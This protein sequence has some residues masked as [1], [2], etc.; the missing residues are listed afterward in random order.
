M[1]PFMNC[2]GGAASSYLPEGQSG[3]AKELHLRVTEERKEGKAS[4]RVLLP[5]VLTNMTPL[6]TMPEKLASSS[7]VTGYKC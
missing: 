4:M 6:K 2:T 7:K 5:E 1:M 3:K